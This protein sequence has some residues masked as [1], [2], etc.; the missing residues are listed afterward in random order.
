[1]VT[2]AHP[3]VHGM[4]AIGAVGVGKPAPVACIR[5]LERK[6][7]ILW[8][9][10]DRADTSLAEAEC[11]D[12]VASA[13]AAG[14][15]LAL[16][17][18]RIGQNWSLIVPWPDCDEC[19]QVR[20][21]ALG[22]CRAV[23]SAA[24]LPQE[25]SWSSG[26]PRAGTADAFVHQHRAW[27]GFASVLINPAMDDSHSVFTADT[28]MFMDEH[29]QLAPVGGKGATR[30][31]ALASCLG[32]GIE[33]YSLVAGLDR[34]E[35]VTMRAGD[36]RAEGA[37]WL[38]AEDFDGSSVELDS[39]DVVELVPLESLSSGARRLFPASLV[40]APFTPGEGHKSPTPSSTTGA[41]AGATLEEAT[42]QAVLELIERDSFWYYSR[43]GG[44]LPELALDDEPLAAMIA[45]G[46]RVSIHATALPNPFRV[47]VVHVTM[48]RLDA[49]GSS[50]TARGMGASTTWAS[51]A[52]K[53]LIEAL[54]MLR[55]LDTGID[56]V[57]SITDMRAVWY[58]GASRELFPQF[59]Q[60]VGRN[61]VQAPDRSVELSPK[62]ESAA[63]LLASL[64]E[65][66]EAAGVGLFRH[67]LDRGARYVA[68]RCIADRI[69][70]L[71]DQYFPSL[72]RFGDW[73]LV[74]GSSPRRTYSGPLFM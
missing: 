65:R 69:L 8:K 37:P 29:E 30:M 24:E 7:A 28:A 52:R 13:A 51:A 1:M 38:P 25:V 53:A 32:E 10:V 14:F 40:F 36:V 49:R 67:I 45:Q 18:A 20:P 21:H 6:L 42:V 46:Q 5:C 71:D 56:V 72:N 39:E 50:R 16:T 9:R 11:R 31:Q 74:D 44:T 3:G 43:C 63:E 26:V 70:P 48:A 34:R 66:A 57:P 17:N 19:R 4:F 2:I 55:S 58:D 60:S 22:L 62:T 61:S 68:V 15:P 33:R 35:L 47:P 73:S 54:Q 23:D 27:F 12:A 64:V 59:F 41:A